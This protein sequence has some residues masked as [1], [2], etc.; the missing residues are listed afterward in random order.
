MNQET[1]DYK[2]N[3]IESEEGG[4]FGLENDELPIKKS[5]NKTTVKFYEGRVFASKA[6]AGDVALMIPRG[7]NS[8]NSEVG[9]KKSNESEI[10][11]E[12][13]AIDSE[14]EVIRSAYNDILDDY[15]NGVADLSELEQFIADSDKMDN[16][17]TVKAT[18]FL[19]EDIKLGKVTP[20]DVSV[21]E[22]KAK[23]DVRE[24]GDEKIETESD[25]LVK[26]IQENVTKS[27]DH[28][29]NELV[30]LEREVANRRF[31]E[32]TKS[33]WGYFAEGNKWQPKNKD[34]RVILTDNNDDDA[35]T[36]LYFLKKAG[37]ESTLCEHL[38]KFKQHSSEQEMDKNKAVEQFNKADFFDIKNDMPPSSSETMWHLL[39]ASGVGHFNNKNDRFL[40]SLVG[41]SLA[42]EIMNKP[43]HFLKSAKTLRGLKR[44]MPASKIVA[45]ANSYSKSV[46]GKKW[47]ENY[48]NLLDREFSNEDLMNFGVVHVSAKGNRY[49]DGSKKQQET[50]DKAMNILGQTESKLKTD[51][52]LVDSSAWGKVFVNIARTPEER[53]PGGASSVH[54]MG[55]YDAYLQLQPSLDQQSFLF[56]PLKEKEGAKP[57]MELDQGAWVYGMYLKLKDGK[58]FSKSQLEIMQAFLG[59]N[60]EPMGVIKE[61]LEQSLL[62][63]QATKKEKVSE[64]EQVS[65]LE[66]KKESKF[67]KKD[68]KQVDYLTGADQEGYFWADKMHDSYDPLASVFQLLRDSKDSTIAKYVPVDDP[69]KQRIMI[70]SYTIYLPSAAVDFDGTNT[71]GS[72]IEMLSPGELKLEGEKWMVTKKIKVRI[73]D[74][75]SKIEVQ[76]IDMNVV[77]KSEDIQPVQV[78]ESKPEPIIQGN[79]EEEIG[80]I[81]NKITPPPDFKLGRAYHS[82]SGKYVTVSGYNGL[83]SDNRHYITTENNDSSLPFDE[84]D[85][86][87]FFNRELTAEERENK[88]VIDD[89]FRQALNKFWHEELRKPIY[90]FTNEMRQMV[91]S[92]QIEKSM[93]SPKTQAILFERYKKYDLP[94]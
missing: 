82:K 87:P 67:E 16:S 92:Q 41:D 27:S 25:P 66:L 94:I 73:T 85:Y 34:H 81:E 39:M 13:K 43:D 93:K 70:A 24:L 56:R 26:W 9:S 12:K 71:R 23:E 72:Y 58:E 11:A 6:K 7:K 38:L 53:F 22:N 55:K 37:L 79:I 45:Y 51:G 29:W 77:E 59:K 65:E 48:E 69:F 40:V 89:K 2:F 78:G 8:R 28:K 49:F 60:Y 80:V 1:S 75:P 20:P 50:V 52:R 32:S 33:V 68:Y 4:E 44:F 14:P 15:K 74:G 30:D 42:N 3:G 19:V 10:S 5:K 62:I 18:R 35:K 17:P 86:E 31:I 83:A 36:T 90:D 63:N 76:P 84:I 21:L 54:A 47:E 61:H 57:N 91:V 64:N 88:E 46:G